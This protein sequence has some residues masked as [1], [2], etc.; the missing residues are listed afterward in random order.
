MGGLDWAGL[1]MVAAIL[2]VD[3]LELFVHRLV[4]IKTHQPPG[5]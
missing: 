5:A 4:T 2:G 3:D 1:P